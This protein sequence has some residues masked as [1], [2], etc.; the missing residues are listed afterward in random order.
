MSHRPY[1]SP[2]RAL[3]QVDRHDEE[4]PPHSDPQ[5]GRPFPRRA[6]EQLSA[7]MRAAQP[8]GLAM[9]TQLRAAFQIRPASG[10][11]RDA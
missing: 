2:D 7:F 4:T 6:G 9:G 1:P 3:H 5:P 8:S 11:V 10:Q